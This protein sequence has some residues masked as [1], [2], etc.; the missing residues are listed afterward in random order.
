MSLIPPGFLNCV[1]AIGTKDSSDEMIWI[2]TG[3]LYGKYF[4][5]I[6]IDEENNQYHIFLITNKHV[7]TGL[8]KIYVRFNP[9]NNENSE[10]FKI[11]LHKDK[12]EL[13]WKGHPDKEIDVAGILINPNV[14]EKFKLKYAYFCSDKHVLFNEDLVSEDLSEGDHI[15]VL[16]F[17]MGL[18]SENRQ[19]VICRNCCISRISDFKENRSKDFLID[20]FVFPGNSGGPVITKPEFISIE[21]TKPLKNARLIGMVQ[22]Y[23]PYRVLKLKN[24]ESFL[25]KIQVYLQLS[26]LNL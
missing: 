18:V 24:L 13:I 2:G 3:F 17:P 5:R 23:V 6:D 15:F 14:L 22:T 21:G 11:L 25:K 7:L 10:D 9:K 20:A 26:Q 12:N 1:V 19:Y 8:D 16:G 4:Q